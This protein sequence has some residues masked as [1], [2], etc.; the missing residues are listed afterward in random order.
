VTITEDESVLSG[1]RR[2]VACSP[3]S[4]RRDGGRGEDVNWAVGRH[5]TCRAF[6]D[7]A[8]HFPSDRIMLAAFCA[9][10]GADH[11]EK[12]VTR[13]GE[14]T[15]SSTSTAQSTESSLRGGER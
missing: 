3:R 10:H 11:G 2:R 15:G 12:Q 14:I 4:R 9:D 6:L 7:S 1:R 5:L 13:A 8:H